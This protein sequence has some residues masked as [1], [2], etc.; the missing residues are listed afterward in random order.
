MQPFC[1]SARRKTLFPSIPA[2]N[3]MS[4][5]DIRPLSDAKGLSCENLLVESEQQALGSQKREE[6]KGSTALLCN[7]LGGSFCTSAQT[8]KTLWV[9]AKW[10]VPFTQS[11]CR[12][13]PR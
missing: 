2:A 12:W 4:I 11:R 6:N 10:R 9:A 8:S 5:K 13:E 1:R 7:G 3:H